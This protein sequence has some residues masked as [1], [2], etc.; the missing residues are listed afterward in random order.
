MIKKFLKL[1]IF[2]L[3]INISF[4][5]VSF[6]VPANPNPVEVTQPDGTKIKIRVKGD[7]FYNWVEDERGYTVIK[8]T[9]TKY[10]TYAQKNITGRL[11]PSSNYVG[12]KNML[13]TSLNSFQSSPAKNLVDDERYNAGKKRREEFERQT[14]EIYKARQKEKEL[15]NKLLKSKSNIEKTGAM[16]TKTALVILVQFQNLKFNQ[17]DPFIGQ[18]DEQIIQ[19][20]DHLFNKENYRYDEAIGSVK[21]YFKEVS[22]GN[23]EYKAVIA[24]FIITMDEDY[25]YYGDNENPSSTRVRNELVPKALQA[26]HEKGFNYQ[27][28]WPGKNQPEI[29]SIIQAGGDAA[30][31]SG[32]FIW[33]HKWSLWPSVTYD[34]IE[35][36]TYNIMAGFRGDG[37]TGI[38][39][40]GV[41]AHETTHT[42]G[43][44][45][46]Y[47]TTS[48]S[49]GIGN[50]CLMAGG[51]WGGGDGKS[52]AHPCAWIK[53]KLGWTTTTTATAGTNYI[54]NSEE[55]D[56][57]IYKFTGK[58]FSSS[59]EYFLIENRQPKGFDA[60]L[61]GA[62]TGKTGL[63]IYHIDDRIYD[64]DIYQDHDQSVKTG[65]HYMVAIEE[66]D[67]TSSDWKNAHMPKK[68]DRGRDTD[69]YRGGTIKTYTAF[70]DTDTN[71]P[72]AKSYTGETSGIIIS[73]ISASGN[74]MSFYFGQEPTIYEMFIDNLNDKGISFINYVMNY[75]PEKTKDELKGLNLTEQNKIKNYFDFETDTNNMAS[76]VNNMGEVYD[77]YKSNNKVYSILKSSTGVVLPSQAI[78]IMNLNY[79]LNKSGKTITVGNI[80]S[81]DESPLSNNITTDAII[82]SHTLVNENMRFTGSDGVTAM[83]GYKTNYGFLMYKFGKMRTN[84]SYYIIELNLDTDIPAYI[85]NC[86]FIPGNIPLPYEK[87]ID[88]LDDKGINFINF[89]MKYSPAKTREQLKVLDSQERNKIKGFFDFETDAN[90][91]NKINDMASLYYT[92]TGS[93][94]VCGIGKEYTGKVSSEQANLIIDLNNVLLQSEQAITSIGNISSANESPLDNETTHSNTIKRFTGVI[95]IKNIQTYHKNYGTLVY[96]FDKMFVMNRSYDIMEVTANMDTDD[97][98]NYYWLEGEKKLAFY[99]LSQI[100]CCP[101]P[102][103][104]GYICIERLPDNLDNFSAEIF[105]MTAKLVKSFGAKDVIVSNINK[106]KWNCKNRNGENVAPG[107][108]LL[109]IKNAGQQKVFKI[110]VIR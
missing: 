48:A 7:E 9:Q 66:A 76:K 99:D 12:S 108:Y 57:A 30:A 71:K 38:I 100:R 55:N 107:V 17:K 25:Q 5:N 23:F 96:S 39:R 36:T 1:F 68:W 92:Y 72:N 85:T 27:N 41:I 83:T 101:N 90:M 94:M 20:Y 73:Q 16:E 105:T 4:Y 46:L 54:N 29:F 103:R 44:P 79:I 26:L 69:Y 43:M 32:D 24:P 70:N 21:D 14:Q 51:S 56:D 22:Y 61:P 102:A 89:I 84:N 63:L 86:V 109:L 18:T 81:G 10:W 78:T 50:F 104:D 49:E 74:I 60:G 59:K 53:Y 37:S 97:Y 88:V 35:F 52:P 77:S 3:F 87:V 42:L 34:D 2:V 33:S 8:D 64:G 106:L 65:E 98:P 62:S 58:N 45:D 40:V 13:T 75:L 28:I 31:G 6:A 80:S 95:A 47:D 15:Q 67:N 93:G 91:P 82:S 110:A 19:A 11:V